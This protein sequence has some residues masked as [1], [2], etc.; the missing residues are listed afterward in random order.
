M[1][2]Q[3]ERRSGALS[4]FIDT[5]VDKEKS[6]PLSIGLNIEHNQIRSMKGWNESI[7]RG[8]QLHTLQGEIDELF[9]FDS[10]LT[11]QQIT[12]LMEENKVSK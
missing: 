3:L 4:S 7:K 5:L 11:P 10:A 9:F 6:I 8:K 1:D 2:G 12:Q